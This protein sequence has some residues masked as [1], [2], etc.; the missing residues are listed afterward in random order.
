MIVLRADAEIGLDGER[1]LQRLEREI[2]GTETRT[3]SGESVVYVGC[4]G[5]A[6]ECSFKHLLRRDV[7]AT[8]QF[9]DAAVIKRIGVAGKHAFGT[10]ARFRDREIRAGAGGH[11]RNL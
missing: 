8:V 6:L 2:D 9:D 7:L 10:Q 4:F 5:F 3:G 1:A 11:F